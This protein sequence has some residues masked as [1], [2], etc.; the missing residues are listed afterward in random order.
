M[1]LRKKRTNKSSLSKIKASDVVTSLAF[2][3]LF[4]T[5]YYQLYV[6]L[7]E[8]LNQYIYEQTHQNLPVIH[9]SQKPE[10]EEPVITA[11]PKSITIPEIFVSNLPIVPGGIIGDS[12]LLFNDKA[13][14]L[15]TSGL[16]GEGYN[17]VIYAHSRN[18]LFKNI[19]ELEIGNK[20]HILGDNDVLYSYE[21]Y[22]KET[23]NLKEVSKLKSTQP[24]II[25][26][27]T[28]DGPL[29]QDR[30]IIRASLVIE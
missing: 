6:K 28:C 10:I 15:Q 16:L 9:G 21:V 30:V 13:T 26:L 19:K 2:F 12:W 11:I 7:D 18:G 24:N 27:F 29:D 22:G 23:V 14:Y 5:S 17:T 1:Q 3:V 20:I 25:T 4:T 8:K